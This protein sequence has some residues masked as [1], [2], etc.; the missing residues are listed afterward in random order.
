M[1]IMTT[2]DAGATIAAAVHPGDPARSEVAVA[3][4]VSRHPPFIIP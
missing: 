2:M 1:P 3:A 4:I